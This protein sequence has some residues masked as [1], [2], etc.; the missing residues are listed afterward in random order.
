MSQY[1]LKKAG[2]SLIPGGQPILEQRL[3]AF[4]SEHSLPDS[5]GLISRAENDGDFEENL[6]SLMTIHETLWFRDG[7]PF[8]NI[9][10]VLFDKF[11]APNPLKV[12]SAACSTGQEAYSLKM[13][14]LL[15]FPNRKLEILGTDICRESVEQAKLGKYDSFSMSRGI[16]NDIRNRYF[17]SEGNR[18]AVKAEIKEG[19]SFQTQ[20]LLSPLKSNEYFH[21]ILL[22]NVIIYFPMEVKKN[23]IDKIA[24]QLV[25][26]GILLLG[27]CESIVGMNPMLK[28]KTAQKTIFYEKI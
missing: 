9:L 25:P 8:S 19:L 1:M 21:L 15:N 28:L 16:A 22:R 20:N 7:H 23:L 4:A 11:N 27:G 14:Q 17:T 24:H 3:R 12:W 18:W 6:F 26:G 13:S 5:H 2:L 10:P